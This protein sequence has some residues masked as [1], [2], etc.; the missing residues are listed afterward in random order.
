MRFKNIAKKVTKWGVILTS[1]LWPIW[2]WAPTDLVETIYP[3]VKNQQEAYRI[4]EEE[5]NKL[6]IKKPVDLRVYENDE[7]RE[8][9]SQGYSGISSDGE[10]FT[11]GANIGDLDRILLRHELYHIHRGDCEKYPKRV[12]KTKEEDL[13]YFMPRKENPSLG[14]PEYFYLMEPRANIYSITGIKL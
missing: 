11:I 10:G 13:E 3:N 14:P 7:L 12:G 5:K 6:G 8:F 1:P 2:I 9:G 4:L